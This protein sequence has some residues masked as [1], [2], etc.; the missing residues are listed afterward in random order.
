MPFGSGSTFT[1]AVDPCRATPHLARRRHNVDAPPEGQ[2]ALVGPEVGGWP[3]WAAW[4]CWKAR[5]INSRTIAPT[6][7]LKMPPS[8][9]APLLLS[10]PKRTYPRKPPAYEP[11]MPRISVCHHV[12]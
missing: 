7:E 4:R 2:I 10:Q 1:T 8:W 12:I 5:Q 3:E 6:I 11:R 9:M